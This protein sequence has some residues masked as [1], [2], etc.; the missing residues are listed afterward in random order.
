MSAP[1]ARIED[2]AV[3]GDMH[4]AALVDRRGR[5]DWLC[6]PHFD[7]GATFTSLLG[8]EEHGHWTIAPA[9]ETVETSRAYRPGTLILETI[10]RCEE[11]S[12]RLVDF[13][14]LREE[15]ATV[16]RIV[17]GIEGR[18]PM[19]LRLVP[20]FEYGYTAPWVLPV[21][22]GAVAFTGPNAFYLH[23]STPVA[24]DF[25]G[26]AIDAE[27]ELAEGHEVRFVMTWRNSFEDP[28][29]PHD[30]IAAL[31]ETEAWWRE[32]TERCT[33]QGE[34]R[35]QVV[36]SLIALKAMTYKPTGA[37][38]AAV[39]ASLPEEIGGERNWDYRYCWIRD[40]SLLLHALNLG[41]YMHEQEEFNEWVLRVIAGPP[42]QGSILYGIHGDRWLPE[43]TLEWLPGYEGSAPVRIGNAAADQ[44]QLDIF[45]EA[46]DA[47]HY[48]WARDGHM[49]RPELFV[50][51]VLP[52]LAYVE[53]RWR[54]PDEGIWEVRG[55]RRHFTYSKV[56]AWVAF[57][58][59]IDAQEHLGGEGGP[60]ERWRKIRQEIHDEVC[61]EGF[62]DARGTFTQSYGS[63]ELDA[64][65]LLIPAVGFL[66]VD[67][68]RVI[69]TVE[70]VERELTEDGFVYRYSTAEGSVDGL[71]GREGVFLACS[72][73]LVD[74]LA[75]IGRMGD[76][77]SLFERLLSLAN[78]VGLYAEEYDPRDRRQLGNFP[79]AFTHLALVNSAALLSGASAITHGRH[80]PSRRK[81]ST[82]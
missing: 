39:T 72:F 47:A 24:L 10:F 42:G 59:A 67:D 4:T 60:I 19:R 30:P 8:G 31:A 70:T 54:E 64:S 6:L 33:Y 52:V 17:E 76:A 74:A 56:M 25:P 28:P 51:T 73:W 82:A 22:G 1:T 55:P 81:A 53:Q 61:R 75:M 79:Q 26:L 41:G 77:R 49:D 48:R 16:V 21:P 43:K 2:H 68:D 29:E 78:D 14:P 9:V 66:P 58:R 11:G 27:F 13:M 7:S 23:A 45:G 65:A 37:V 44:F 69:G 34:W 35:D 18:V 20:R 5:I 62:D 38:V 80:A 15:H 50:A 46:L 57:D 71:A 36:T 12:V 32:W 63:R 3:I 40:S